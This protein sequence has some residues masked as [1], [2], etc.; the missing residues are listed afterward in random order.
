MAKVKEKFARIVLSSKGRQVVVLKS[1]SDNE[2]TPHAIEAT[3][4]LNGV[5]NTVTLEYKTRADRNQAFK[6]YS[7]AQADYLY[8]VLENF[9]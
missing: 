1:W 9:S 7:Q 3:A 6:E 2:D 5:R 4:Q 8:G